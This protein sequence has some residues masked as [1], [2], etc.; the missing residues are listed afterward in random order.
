MKEHYY[1]ERVR[2]S[3]TDSFGVVYYTNYLRWI[4]AAR[5]EFIRNYTGK[6][7]KDY[8]LI[9]QRNQYISVYLKK[10]NARY[11]MF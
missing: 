3:D 9:R 2:Y 1:F 6:S 5:T 8:E 7:L 4:E 10:L 11:S